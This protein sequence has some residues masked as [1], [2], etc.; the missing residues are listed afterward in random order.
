MK[1]RHNLWVALAFIAPALLIYLFY[2]IIPIPASIFYSFFQWN[3]LPSHYKLTTPIFK[4]NGARDRF[5]QR[6]K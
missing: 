3:G 5:L 1:H 6:I 4:K 2:F